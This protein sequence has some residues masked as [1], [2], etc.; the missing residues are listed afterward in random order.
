MLEN[1][2]LYSKIDNYIN[3]TI[4]EAVQNALQALVR[5]RFKELSEFEMK[6]ILHDQMFESGSYKSQPEHA[7]LY[8]ALE[9]SM[10][11]EN[12]EEFV[13]AT[14]K[15]R[16]RRRDDQD[17]RPPH[18]KDSDQNKKKRHDSD[19]STSK[20]SLAQT[21]SAWNTSDIREGPSRSSKQKTVFQSEQP[22]EDVP[23]PDDVHFSDSE[24]TDV[25]HLPKIKTRPDWLK[26]I[27]E[28]ERPETPE[29][30][31]S[32]PPNDLPETENNWANAI[33]KAYK[34][35]EENK[36]IRKTRDMGSFIKWYCKQIGKSKIRKTNLEGLAFKLVR[37][38]HK[39][40]IYLQFYMEECHLLLTDQI[41]LVNPKG[42]RVVPDVSKPLPLGGPP[43]QIESEYE[44]DISAAYGISHWWFK[45][46]EFY[47][48]RHSAPSDH[49]V[50]KSDMKILSVVS[51]KTF[52]Q[53]GYAFLR[54]IVL[55]KADYKDYKISKADF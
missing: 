1:H 53:Y 20:Q 15:S 34:D 52:S 8:N 11:R 48:T 4:K 25:A 16:K 5:D 44:Y 9:A 35:L 31:C 55:R 21:S 28:E 33:S 39:N 38:F 30:D 6:E 17:P 23:I 49:R 42:N 18:P 10:D 50:V 47:I 3:E 40:N 54:E 36:L 27:P 45:C 12:R 22:V 13:E 19:T 37:P 46:K 32:V 41:D 2:D 7:A 26:P 14:A 43:G 29:P 51:L 24:K